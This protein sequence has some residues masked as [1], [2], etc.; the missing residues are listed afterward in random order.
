MRLLDKVLMRWRFRMALRWVPPGVA[1]LDVGCH[2]GEFFRR[3]GTR[4]GSGVG[5]DPLAQPYTG[6]RFRL[7]AEAFPPAT[8]LPPASFD[9]IVMLAALEH[10]RDN[11]DLPGELHR[12]LRPGG[13]LILTVPSPSVDALVDLLCRLRL[14]DGMSVEQH[15]GFSPGEVPTLFPPAGF[16]LEHRQRFQ[17]GLNNLFVFRKPTGAGPEA[18]GAAEGTV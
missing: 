5:F 12:L 11:A 18:C 1:L 13:R 2:Q 4:L 14:A 15:Y 6:E 9:A 16:T 7:V 10:I 3:L 17:L 8:P